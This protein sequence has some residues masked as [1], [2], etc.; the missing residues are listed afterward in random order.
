VFASGSGDDFGRETGLL[1]LDAVDGHLQFLGVGVEG[2]LNFFAEVAIYF[3]PLVGVPWDIVGIPLG[4]V[5]FYELEPYFL[6]F[7][8]EMWG[9]EFH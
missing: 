3:V 1:G 7:F 2:A 4:D 9:E 6:V 5:A 8:G